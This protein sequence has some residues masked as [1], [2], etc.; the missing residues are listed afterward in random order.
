MSKAKK[1]VRRYLQ[2]ADESSPSKPGANNQ[3]APQSLFP[4][5]TLNDVASCLTVS[6]KAKS[7]QEMDAAIKKGVVKR[8][9]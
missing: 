2:A 8:K 6:G 1:A 5:T 3:D 4:A 9:L 7:L